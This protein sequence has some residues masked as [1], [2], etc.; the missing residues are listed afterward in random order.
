MNDWD[1]SRRAAELAASLRGTAL[2][3]LSSLDAADRKDYQKLSRALNT[4][5]NSYGNESE[6][7]K[8]NLRTRKRRQG[9]SLAELAQEIRGLVRKAYPRATGEM[10]DELTIAAFTEA[11]SDADLEWAVVSR[12]PSTTEEAVIEATRFEA[13]R[14]SRQRKQKPREVYAL[15]EENRK[16]SKGPSPLPRQPQATCPI[17][18]QPGNP[19]RKIGPNGTSCWF[20]KKD[21]HKVINCPER[22]CFYCRQPGHIVPACPTRAIDLKNLECLN[23][24]LQDRQSAPENC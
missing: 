10:C 23:Q 13:F 3:V 12:R 24:R 17:D 19:S 15:T 16:D 14:L 1:Y 7:Y 11:L 21:G 22:K 6:I 18:H 20:C 5:F 4:R 8:A 9:E 2:S